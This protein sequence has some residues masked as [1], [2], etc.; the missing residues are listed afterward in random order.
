V[1]EEYAAAA[2]YYA[3][4]HPNLGGRFYGEI[5]DLIETV[6]RQ[7]GLFRIFEHPAWRHFST[8]FPYAVVYIDQPECIWIVAIM[9]C[10]RQPGYWKARLE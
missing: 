10:K 2:D 4:V 5:E 6:R 8:V 3:K 9:N 1:A 7:P